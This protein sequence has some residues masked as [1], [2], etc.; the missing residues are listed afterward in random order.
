MEG[1]C[2]VRRRKKPVQHVL[3]EIEF[4]IAKNS[5]LYLKNAATM[6]SKAAS[7]AEMSNDTDTLLQIAGAWLE[8]GKEDK[9]SK[10]PKRKPQLSVGFTPLVERDI[11]EEEEYEEYEDE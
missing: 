10:K 8:I 11:I 3:P 7:I 6:L 9:R 1:K 5:N 4:S 2:M